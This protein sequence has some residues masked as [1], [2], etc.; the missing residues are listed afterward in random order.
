MNEMV[1]K[2]GDTRS[3]A[4]FR[5]LVNRQVPAKIRNHVSIVQMLE[6]KP[7]LLYECKRTS[8]KSVE[9]STWVARV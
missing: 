9:Y 5:P 2:K 1:L 3:T 8:V 7:Y 4:A 6:K